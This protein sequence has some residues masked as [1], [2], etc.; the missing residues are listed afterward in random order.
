[1]LLGKQEIAHC[2]RTS[3]KA[4]ENS[5]GFYRSGHSPL[6]IRVDLHSEARINSAHFAE[7]ASE[8]SAGEARGS[9]LGKELAAPNQNFA[10]SAVNNYDL[11]EAVP[12]LDDQLIHI[13]HAVNLHAIRPRVFSPFVEHRSC[14]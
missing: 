1:M 13:L 14:R 7:A 10:A 9:Q 12:G 4:G 5:D 6:A 8:G 3:S 2:V 11:V